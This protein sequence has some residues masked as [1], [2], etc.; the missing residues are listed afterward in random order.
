MKELFDPTFE[1]KKQTSEGP[2]EKLW[3]RIKICVENFDKHKK[4]NIKI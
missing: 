2:K 1:F 4:M 3:K